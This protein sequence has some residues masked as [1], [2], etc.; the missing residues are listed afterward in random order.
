MLY[1]KRD[2]AIQSKE[3]VKDVCKNGNFPYQIM[4]FLIQKSGFCTFKYSH[5]YLQNYAWASLHEHHQNFHFL[6]S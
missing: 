5:I 3:Y 1:K 6:L 4:R 2:R